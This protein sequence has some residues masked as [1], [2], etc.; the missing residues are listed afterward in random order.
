MIDLKAFRTDPQPYVDSAQRRGL[1]IDFDQI[2]KLDQQRGQLQTKIDQGRS[3]LNVKGKPDAAALAKL[4]SAKE[5][6]SQQEAELKQ[7]EAKLNG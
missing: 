7:L 5:G 1:K 3:E 4:R 2:T 6:I